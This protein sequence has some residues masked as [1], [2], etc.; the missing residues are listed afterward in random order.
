[1]LRRVAEW[2]PLRLRLPILRM[3]PLLRL[4]VGIGAL[5]VIVPILVEP[6]F[7][8]VWQSSPVSAWRS[9]S[10][11]GL[12]E[13]PRGG[14]GHDL[15]GPY[16]PGDWIKLDGTRR[17]QADRS[18]APCTCDAYDNEV[19]IPHSRLWSKSI[20]NA[21]SGSHSVLCVANF[22]CTPTMTARR[23]PAPRCSR[24]DQRL[25]HA[26]NAGERCRAGEALGH[27]LQVK[28]T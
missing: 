20:S 16:Q 3:I 11:Q 9:P 23:A 24:G 21:T 1:V 25:P 26:W 13:Q 22:Y 17:G 28:A 15:E 10:A 27:A 12:R 14:R 4:V 8:N 2:A 6:T 19:I 5:V 7:Q 18:A